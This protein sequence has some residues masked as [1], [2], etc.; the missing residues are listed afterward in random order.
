[1][2]FTPGP[3]GAMGDLDEKLRKYGQCTLLSWFGEI[4]LAFSRF[5]PIF[6]YIF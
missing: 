3:Y 2:D 6:S 4:N 1:L 5:I